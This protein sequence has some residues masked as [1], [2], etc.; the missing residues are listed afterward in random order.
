MI[1]ALFTSTSTAIALP[2]IASANART[3]SRSARSNTRNSTRASGLSALIRS[4]A[5]CPFASLRLVSITRAPCA[6][7]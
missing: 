5:A 7:S 2:V 1:P 3:E 4:T 6:A